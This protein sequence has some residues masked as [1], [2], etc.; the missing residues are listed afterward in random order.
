MSGVAVNL[1]PF[2]VTI[3][4]RE[5]GAHLRVSS[6]IDMATAPVLDDRL[7]AAQSDGY[8]GIVVDL[9]CETKRA[10]IEQAASALIERRDFWSSGRQPKSLA[11]SRYAISRRAFRTRS[12]VHGNGSLSI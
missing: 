8:N 7:R 12:K 2:Y 3:E 5:D 6:E 9:E 1:E 11:P 4:R 10:V